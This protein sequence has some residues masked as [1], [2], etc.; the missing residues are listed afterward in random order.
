MSKFTANGVARQTIY[1]RCNPLRPVTFAAREI[2]KDAAE[3]FRRL[4]YC[5]PDGSICWAIAGL[6]RAQL[7]D[8]KTVA[9]AADESFRNP[10][11]NLP[12]AFFQCLSNRCRRAGTSLQQLFGRVEILPRVPDRRPNAAFQDVPA[13]V[14]RGRVPAWPRE[15]NP[16]AKGRP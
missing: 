9:A 3:V 7:L 4:G 2:E 6:V 1:G 16:T 5:G 14:R 15:A 10:G 13:L 12:A 11:R 8:P